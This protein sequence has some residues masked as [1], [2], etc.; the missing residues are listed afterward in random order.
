[1]SPEQPLWI[2]AREG[3]WNRLRKESLDANAGVRLEH[4]DPL[5][6][7]SRPMI[8]ATG[9]LDRQIFGPEGM[10]APRWLRFDGDELPGLIA[11]PVVDGKPVALAACVPMANGGWLVDPVGTCAPT[12]WPEKRLIRTVLKLVGAARAHTVWP[13][14]SGRLVALDVEEAGNG[15][16]AQA[17]DPARPPPDVEPLCPENEA[18][19]AL[20]PFIVAT[21]ETAATL[22]KQPFGRTIADAHVLSPSSREGKQM[23]LRLAR[24]DAATF[25]PEGMPMPRW[26]FFD[27]GALPGAIVGLGHPAERASLAAMKVL[28][29]RRDAGGL[30]PYAMYIAV[31]SFEPR[32]WVG[33][34]LASLAARLPEEPLQGLGAYTKSVALAVLQARAQIGATQWHSPALRLHARLGPIALLSAWTPAHSDPASLV[35]EAP[36]SAA[37]LRH[38]CRDPRGAVRYPKPEVWIDSRDTGA[39][40]ALQDRI[41]RGERWQLAGVPSRIEA[42]ASLVPIARCAA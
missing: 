14:K 18:L 4:V 38:L 33:H 37:A 42:R 35:Y 28:G 13:R 3:L 26:A 15:E 11:A 32:T 25:G 34:N 29:L 20:T 24:L 12:A 23:I 19:S 1:M 17:E 16:P 30:V 27:A 40:W 31:P 41:E 5:K 22:L 10:S 8:D 9:L 6:R 21:E 2:I 36:I 39:V 7:A